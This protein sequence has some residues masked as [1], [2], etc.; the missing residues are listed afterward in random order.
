[1]KVDC[2]KALKFRPAYK[3][4]VVLSARRGFTLIELLVVIAIIAILAAMSLPALA[5]AKEAARLTR[6]LNNMRQLALCWTM[7]IGDCNDAMPLNY[8]QNGYGSLPDDWVTGDVNQ[9]NDPNAIIAGT[10]YPYN[11]SL[12][13]YQ[14]P[15]LTP[16]NGILF[17]RS[18]S[19]MG[20]MGAPTPAQ[21]VAGSY[22]DPSSYLGDTNAAYQKFT[23]IRNPGP[24]SAIV[25]VDESKN[26]I[27]DGY[28][29]VTLNTTDNSPTMRHNQGGVFSF[30]DSH[31][32]HWRWQ[33]ITQEMSGGVIPTGTGQINDFNRM[34][35]GVV[36]Q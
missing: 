32:E 7:Y 33:G 17:V 6:C 11:K 35:A 22:L 10:L 16:V 1:M 9:A 18:V 24:A 34:L 28:F 19:M 27:D 20:R 3:G 30:A 23:Q 36:A 8:A 26:S 29:S 15:D 5:R 12:E 31:V 4:T 25:F 13:I 14:C 2:A 21:S